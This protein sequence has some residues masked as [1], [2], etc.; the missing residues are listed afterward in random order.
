MTADPVR[1]Y[2]SEQGRKGAAALTT[3]QRS[4]GGKAGGKSRARKLT[5]KRRRE[6]ARR[7]ARARWGEK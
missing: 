2:L 5:P 6:I 3:E 4:N 1:D 7:A